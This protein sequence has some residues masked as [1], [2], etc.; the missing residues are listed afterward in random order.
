MAVYTQLANED[1]A[2]LVSETYGLGEL[3]LAIGIADGVENSN[4]L[5]LV[6]GVD[7]TEQKYILTL[8]EKRVAE[9]DIPFFLNLM[10]HLATHAI[11]CPQPVPRRDG[12]LYGN[13]AE[14]PAAI[15]TFLEGKSRTQIDPAHT[16][17]VGETLAALHLATDGFTEKRMNALALHGWQKL[18]DKTAPRLDEIQP[19]LKMLIED[20]LVHL[21]MNMPTMMSLPRGIIHADLFP[22][23][24][25]F[26]DDAVSGVIDFYFACEDFFAYDLA[27]VVNAWCFEPGGEFNRIKARQL[28]S[29]YQ[30]VRP[31]NDAEK[32]ALPVL[33]RGAALRFLLTRAHDM[34]FPEPS[35]LVTPRD[36][37]EYA[38]KL[39]FHQQVK[40]AGEYGVN[41]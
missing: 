38:I 18:F 12:Q 29:Q 33:M 25:F 22:D 28:M 14:K 27:I 32:A 31:L 23:N 6:D 17:S 11:A 39:R 40:D 2:T 30:R 5:L 35:A 7:E 16:A 34:L 8:Y 24:V 13:V 26:I 36:P 19:G 41:E 10:Q 3:T 15:V 9:G 4:Y 1:I 20:E 21:S 37:V